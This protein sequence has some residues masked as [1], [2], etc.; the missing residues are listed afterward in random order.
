MPLLL[1]IIVF[2]LQIKQLDGLCFS[3]GGSFHTKLW[4]FRSIELDTSDELCT[5]QGEKYETRVHCFLE[6]AWNEL[7]NFSRL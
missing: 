1:H 7:C 6:G 5:Q 2:F 4:V 3:A